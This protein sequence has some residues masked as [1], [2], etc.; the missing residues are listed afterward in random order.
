MVGVAATEQQPNVDRQERQTEALV[1]TNV[2]LL[3]SPNL[4]RRLARRDDHM[5]Q[6][7]R[8]VPPAHEQQVGETSVAHVKKASAAKARTRRGQEADRVPERIGVMVNERR[9]R[10]D[11]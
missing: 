3:V 8:D 10:D 5:T 11:D 6:G 1:L 4:I 7:D 2:Y 9:E